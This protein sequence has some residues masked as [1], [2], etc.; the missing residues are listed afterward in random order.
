[1][2]AREGEVAIETE[3]SVEILGVVAD[4]MALII[5]RFV[6]E[7]RRTLWPEKLPV[8]DKNLAL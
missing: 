1:M 7:W 5:S 3:L 4:A 2:K 6:F 8:L